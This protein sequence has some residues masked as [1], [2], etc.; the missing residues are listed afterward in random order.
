[1]QIGSGT[2][3]TNLDFTYLFQGPIF[4]YGGQLSGIFRLGE[5]ERE[6]AYGNK[7]TMNHWYGFKLTDWF[8]LS[9][10]LERIWTSKIRDKDPNLNPMM[11]ITAD[12]DNSGGNVLNPGL[13][14]NL[15]GPIG[16]T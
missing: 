7:F 11:V 5:N 2:F 12:T 4:S 15:Y 10:R 6:Y 8:S 14:F 16:S 9:A 1:M 13:G 3:D